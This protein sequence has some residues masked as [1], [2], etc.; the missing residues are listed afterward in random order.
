MSERD[1]SVFS[2]KHGVAESAGDTSR[3]VSPLFDPEEEAR[4][5]W[6]ELRATYPHATRVYWLIPEEREERDRERERRHAYDVAI[7][8]VMGSRVVDDVRYWDSLSPWF[9]TEEKAAEYLEE[10]RDQHP[11]ACVPWCQ[12]MFNP[13]DPKR[14]RER[15]ELLARF[16]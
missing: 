3:L 13:D 4:A 2:G 1:D 11:E 16:V 10:I 14:M 8:E 12:M 7:W 9:R 6:E 15:D 5:A